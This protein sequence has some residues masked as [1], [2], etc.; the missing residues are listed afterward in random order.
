MFWYP[1][2][3]EAFDRAKAE[4]KPIFLSIGYSTCYWCHVMER[5]VF[6][7]LSIASQ[8]NRFF[9]NVKVDREEHPELDDFYMLARH[10]MTQEG[11][12]PNNLFLTPDLKPF[13]AGGTFSPEDNYGKPAFPRILE[14]ITNEWVASKDRVVKQADS[15]LE[16][17]KPYLVH[18]KP[19]GA[20]APDIGAQS[21][22]LFKTLKDFHDTRGGGFFQ[23]PKF[24]HETFLQFLLGY[25]EMTGNAQALDIAEFSL[26]KMAAGGIY[27][28][29]GCGFHRYAVDKQ[30]FVPHFEKMLYNQAQLART[31]TDAARITGN[32]YFAD[33]AKSVLDFVSGPLTDGDGAFYTAIDAESDGVE[34]AYYAWKSE[35]IEA[36]L[37]PEEAKF[38]VTFFALADIP[39]FPGHPETPGQVIIARQPLDIAAEQHGMQ[40]IELAAL[41]GH[42]FNK[43]L[44]A[45]NMRSTPILDHKLI[46][47]WN[48]LMIDALA[49]AGMV[50]G[51][52]E[53][54]ER[55]G[56]A[57]QFILERAIDNNGV[58]KRI[59]T[60]GRAT[61][62]AKLEDYAYL[63]RGLLTLA[64]TT[65]D[66]PLLETAKAL[67]ATAEE[68]FADK[69]N[70]GYFSSMDD[71]HLLVRMKSAD[72]S[73]LPSPNAV[74]LHNWVDLFELTGDKMYL[75]RARGLADAFLSG[76]T[77]AVPEFSTMVHGAMRLEA[78]EGEKPIAE[79]KTFSAADTSDIGAVMVQTSLKPGAPKPGEECEMRIL[80]N[81]SEGWHINANK[82]EQK[83]LI[84]TQIEFQE[85]SIELVSLKWPKPKKKTIAG[86][87][88]LIYEG[89]I[90]LS[91]RLKMP[92]LREQ[93]P[94]IRAMLSFQPCK[95]G[96]CYKLQNKILSI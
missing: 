28:H 74:M 64:R 92:V 67:S 68:L 7:N 73:A 42:V 41:A 9:I 47:A 35:E 23:S 20:P 88:L 49:H 45:R 33:I 29:V 56:K 54:I 87:E 48:G 39:T 24:P 19:A 86:E 46:V 50:F 81:I 80:I 8:M 52:P 6:E 43:L 60:S 37:T 76:R 83:D 13:Y 85:R 93:R 3:K 78:Y 5:E 72:D 4:D 63:I 32:T 59:I 82:V 22:T 94:V 75:A 70:G 90:T 77:T 27:D 91:A 53:Y 66:A 57:A 34:G 69:Q 21:A 96:S 2:G 25:N 71:A 55:A 18:N 95:D 10:L 26:R 17:M 16:G 61:I 30:W 31:Y 36:L 84:P 38:F 79:Q 51:K 65:K 15:L 44:N 62:D 89:S 58:L 12:W 14:W 40:Y 1:W 11:G